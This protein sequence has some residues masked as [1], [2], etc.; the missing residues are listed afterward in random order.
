MYAYDRQ[1][2]LLNRGVNNEAER[3]GVLPLDRG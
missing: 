1:L 3:T 2:E